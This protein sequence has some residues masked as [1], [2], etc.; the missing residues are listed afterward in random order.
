M[1]V[2]PNNNNKA[3]M[4]VKLKIVFVEEKKRQQMRPQVAY[5]ILGGMIHVLLNKRG[6]LAHHQIYL[7]KKKL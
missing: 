7:S 2:A 6:C 4:W 1:C 3:S 5:V